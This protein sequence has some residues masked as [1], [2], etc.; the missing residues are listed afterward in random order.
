[1]G[2]EFRSSIGA[3]KALAAAGHRSV[4]S[5]P[6]CAGKS[7]RQIV[8]S[9][10]SWG[11]LLMSLQ[12]PIVSAV[13]AAGLALSLVAC[14]GG[15]KTTGWSSPSATLSATPTPT[16][17]A[18]STTPTVAPTTPAAPKPRTKADLTKALLALSDL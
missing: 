5:C 11:G 18:S 12:R 3:R 16:P 2:P 9:R 15:S 10:H 17:T 13:L 6:R 8:L 4:C 14:G 1:P 7:G